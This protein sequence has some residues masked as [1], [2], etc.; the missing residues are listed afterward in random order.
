MRS[1]F[2][3]QIFQLLRG[4]VVSDLRV[5]P[6]QLALDKLVQHGYIEA[7]VAE[8]LTAAYI[9]LRQTEHRL[10]EVNDQQTHRLPAET[11]GRQRLAVG[12]GYTDWPTFEKE[13][14]RHRSNVQSAFSSLL[15]AQ[16][17]EQ[18]DTDTQT[19]LTELRGIWE[20]TDIDDSA[21]LTLQA[22]GYDQPS[23]IIQ[24]LDNLKQS[25]A[26]L[27]LSVDGRNRLDQ[28]MPRVLHETADTE[29]PNTILARIVQIIES[30]QRR[31]CYIA[32]LQENPQ[33]LKHLIRLVGASPWIASF[34]ARRPVLLDELLDARTLYDPPQRS[35]ME[36]DL[37]QK[38]MRLAPEDLE[39]QIEE[40]CIFRQIHS[41]RVAAADITD[42]LPLMRVSDYLSDIAETVLNEVIDISWDHLVQKHGKPSSNLEGTPCE[43]G[44][45][46]IAYGKLG[47][48]E[49]GYN[50]DLDLVFI[51]AGD[52]G[53]TSG[54][55]T[56]LDNPQFYARLGQRVIHILTTHTAAGRIYEIDMRLRPSG[57]AGMLVSHFN[58][59]KEYQSKDAWTW[60]HQALLRTRAISGDPVLR[61]WFDKTRKEILTRPRDPDQLRTEIIDMRARMRNEL[62]SAREGEFDIKQ[63]HGG[64]VD[65]EFLVQYLVLLKANTYPHL[66]R[67][68][69]NVRQLQALAENGII[70][71]NTAYFL[72]HAYLVYRATTH[73]LN[74]REQPA[75]VPGERFKDLSHN[76]RTIWRQYLDS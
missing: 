35:Q 59:F 60:E 62:L 20:K 7:A 33:A 69:D 75:R 46:V 73:R 15:A 23:D 14:Q 63:G 72:R 74:L 30:I 76:V 50:S 10:Q 9:F 3:G 13:L 41:L 38:L 11:L 45:A 31:T 55:G 49:L 2:F 27:S 25:P 36:S 67:W 40:L 51:H 34:L 5:R 1:S 19:Q 66:V 17:L 6:I 54:D 61:H 24:V 58:G 26:T 56:P 70:D 16:E 64:I 8:E 68:S 52:Q 12:M 42:V 65:I 71:E 21:L 22:I 32:L 47:G 4:G 48:L 28:L 18:K 44:F 29:S 53:Q 43:R 57:T 37:R 39:Y